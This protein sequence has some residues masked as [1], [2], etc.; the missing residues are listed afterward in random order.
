MLDKSR[1]AVVL[2]ALAA[3]LALSVTLLL[4]GVA[5]AADD[6]T[7]AADP[8]EEA[9]ERFRRGVKLYKD[10]DYVAALVEFKRAYE[11]APNYRVLYNL[12][13]TSRGLKDYASAL[14]AYQQYL[15]EGGDEIDD[16]RRKEVEKIVE[17]LTARVGKLTI[18]T[19]VD[20]AEVQIDDEVVGVTPLDEP[21]IVNIGKRRVGASRDGYAPAKR[22]IE[23]AG[24]DE[25][26][27]ELALT[28]LTQKG[29]APANP[30]MP[31]EESH[32]PVA[33]IVALSITT[34]C[35]IGAGVLGGLAL[36]AKSERD[37][38][39]AA[40]PGNPQAI[41][42]AKSK[43]DTMALATDIMIGITS[44]GAITTLVLFLVD[45][46]APDDPEEPVD[47]EGGDVTL[48]VAP[49]GLSLTATF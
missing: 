33:G 1:L 14:T 44:A 22:L 24:R 6:D 46:G 30:M 5:Q 48:N 36:S 39:L 25:L 27:V 7:E 28:D 11:L 32:V 20:G 12:G 10:E 9:S 35:G 37:E 15:D 43:T 4:P 18:T 23:V 34:A 17:D 3:A 40:F 49:T 38:A 16:D 41:T 29:P 42:D 19:N 8:T 31:A 21:I 47:E 26:D 13:Q 2:A 45:P